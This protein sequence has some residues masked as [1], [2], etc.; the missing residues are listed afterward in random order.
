[1]LFRSKY[2]IERDK[3]NAEADRLS[4]EKENLEEEL[5]SLLQKKPTEENNVVQKAR[6]VLS[7]KELTNEML[8]YFID[9]VNVYSGMRL[10]II[11][12][13]Q[14]EMAD[15]IFRLKISC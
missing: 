5:I 11:Y 9:R 13:F 8:L 12:R 6:E 7:A 4:K 10:E 2:L 3:L 15:E 14:D 1:M